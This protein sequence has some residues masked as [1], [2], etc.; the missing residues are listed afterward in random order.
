M[1]KRLL[2]ATLLLAMLLATGLASSGCCHKPDTYV[3]EHEEENT[4]TVRDRNL[5]VE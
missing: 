4:E 2:S 3:E 1:L 5:R